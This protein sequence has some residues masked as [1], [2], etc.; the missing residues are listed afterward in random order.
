MT[1]IPSLETLHIA[2]ILEQVACGYLTGGNCNRWRTHVFRNKDHPTTAN[3]QRY[4]YRFE[5][6][7]RG[8]LHLQ[9]LLWPQDIAVTCADLLNATV[10][11]DNAEDAFVVADTQKSDKSCLKIHTHPT[12]LITLASGKN[13]IEL[14]HTADDADRHIRAH[15]TTIL[16]SLRC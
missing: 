1:E 16:G 2:H 8:T 7:K 12:S 11:W 10:P 14:H 15:L 9:M 5:F 13:T 6:Q 4:F 3:V